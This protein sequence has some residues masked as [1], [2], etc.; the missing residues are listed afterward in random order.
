MCTALQGATSS[1]IHPER[2]PIQ[3]SSAITTPDWG[4]SSTTVAQLHHN[5]LQLSTFPTPKRLNS[6]PTIPFEVVFFTAGSVKPDAENQA[7]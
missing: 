1:L 4:T 3:W 5:D 6:Y 7:C 2:E